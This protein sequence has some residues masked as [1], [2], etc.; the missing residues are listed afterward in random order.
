MKNSYRLMLIAALFVTCL[1]TANII[2]VKV[3]GVG[4]LILPAAVVVFP[5]SYIFGD[6]LTEVYGYKLARRVIWLGFFCNLLFVIFAGIGQIL[7][8]AP[9][10]E[11]QN[12]YNT[13]LGYAPRLLAASFLGYL[14]GEFANSFALAKMKV[15]TKGRW[16]WT[17]TIGSTIVGQTLDTT[18]FIIVAFS[19][20]GLPLPVMIL[21]HWAA[22]V[23]IEILL[24]PVTY[25]IVN[26]LKKKD[27]VD[28]F[29]YQTDF[30]PF[31]MTD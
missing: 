27:T 19:G 10:W 16:L 11:G 2:A 6:I 8:A 15:L 9:G 26:Y 14:A 17:R 24:T 18:I 31:S 12:A 1:I 23:A 21:S 3:I 22:K 28:T 30:N 4:S 25:A 5:L 7:P 13:I 29:D 20:L